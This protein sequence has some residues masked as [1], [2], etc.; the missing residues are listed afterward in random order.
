LR[1]ERNKKRGERDRREERRG[2]GPGRM[3]EWG[4][5]KKKGD[6]RAGLGSVAFGGGK[7]M[8]G[9]MSLQACRNRRRSDQ[10]VTTYLLV[11]SYN[12]QCPARVGTTGNF[13]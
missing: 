10:G 4:N 12:K 8:E 1:E 5:K 13:R 6:G 9:P 2:E 7:E 11:P 3:R